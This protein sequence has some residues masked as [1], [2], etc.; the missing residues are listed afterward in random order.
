MENNL[1]E[2]ILLKNYFIAYF[3]ILG[4]KDKLNQDY[5][6]NNTNT[7]DA[8]KA[9]ISLS[10]KLIKYNPDEIKMKVFSDNF[11]FCAENNYLKLLSLV[12]CL[13]CALSSINIFVRG[14]IVY[15]EIIFD[16]DFIYGKGI[17]NAYKLES[18]ISIFP[19]IIIDDSFF[20]GIKKIEKV[21][22]LSIFESSRLYNI[23]KNIDFDNNQYLNYLDILR[24]YKENGEK[25]INKFIDILSDHADNIKLN[26]ENPDKKIQQKYQW[27]KNYHNE[28][29]KKYNYIDLKI[30]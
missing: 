20:N 18:E 5:E 27:C 22:D 1:N 8:I 14:S 12:G 17:I 13:Q 10:K 23:S 4:Y 29:C 19:R 21:D 16:E 3:D 25:N 24:D 6:D 30:I 9:C 11:F 7:Y 15:D 28:F 26:L 2:N